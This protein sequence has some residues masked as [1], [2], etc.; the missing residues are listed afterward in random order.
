MSLCQQ[1]DSEV[2]LRCS[3][4]V[5]GHISRRFAE[6]SECSDSNVI[7]LP[8]VNESAS[9]ELGSVLDLHGCK[10]A[11]T[12]TMHGLTTYDVLWVNSQFSGLSMTEQRLWMFDCQ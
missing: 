10:Q 2:A 7:G 1:L 9:W 11:C 4:G 6:D 8:R 5:V 3:P 12:M